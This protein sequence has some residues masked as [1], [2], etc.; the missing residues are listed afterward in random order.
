MAVP[1]TPLGIAEYVSAIL[2]TRLSVA[3]EEKQCQKPTDPAPEQVG[4]SSA[5]WLTQG[6]A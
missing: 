4:N 3:R 6:A 5:S 1:L 2:W